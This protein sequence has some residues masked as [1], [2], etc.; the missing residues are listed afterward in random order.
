MYRYGKPQCS[1]ICYYEQIDGKTTDITNEIPFDLPD[2]WVWCRFSTIIK[3]VIGKTPARNRK[4][5]WNAPAL[6]WI[7]IADM[8]QGGIVQQT[9][10]CISTEAL[11]QCFAKKIIPAGTLIMSFKL[12]I[13]RVSISAIPAQHNE[14][15]ISIFPFADDGDCIKNYLF[16]TLPDMVRFVKKSPAIKGNTLNSD[17]LSKMLIPL[18]PRMEQQNI[19][20]AIT[21][22]YSIL[23]AISG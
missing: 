21:Q 2:G 3:F 4:E 8:Q 13:G 11:S 16:K 6:P 18:P 20:Q 14:A 7:S 5:Y 17:S 19:V 12:T 9:K 1:G 22:I 10:E 23:E 15:I